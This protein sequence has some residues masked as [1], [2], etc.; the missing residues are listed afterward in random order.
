M[1]SILNSK[2]P[3]NKVY[4]EITNICNLNC[5]FCAGT[6]RTPHSMTI[7]EFT[8][9]AKQAKTVSDYV[10]FHLMGEPMTHKHL[11]EFFDICQEIGLTVNLTTNGTLLDDRLAQVKNLRKVS[12]SVHSFADNGTLDSNFDRVLEF[13]RLLTDAG[14][15]CELRFW[16]DGQS[17]KIRQKIEA[18]YNGQLPK[19]LYISCDTQFQWPQNANGTADQRAF[20]MG[21]RDQCGILCDGSVVPC[22]LDNDG[23]IILGNVFE[24]PL[25]KI[26][27]SP[28]ARQIYD[29]FS[30]GKAVHPLCKKCTYRLRFNKQ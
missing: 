3:L 20:C 5:S 30:Q 4:I 25:V 17:E 28:L 2:K 18:Y 11:Y 16:I 26:L 13:S 8:K 10:Y 29:G 14:K 19:K 7:E 23:E 9:V 22:C 27:D 21:L 1:T 15:I 12:I 6:K 24:T